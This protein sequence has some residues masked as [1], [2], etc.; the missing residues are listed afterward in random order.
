VVSMSVQFVEAL[1]K[2]NEKEKGPGDIPRCFT[3]RSSGYA[4]F[5]V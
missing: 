2:E 1:K 5:E 4:N 3:F